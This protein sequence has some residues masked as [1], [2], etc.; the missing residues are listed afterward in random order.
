MRKIFFVALLNLF[1]VC[2]YASMPQVVAHRGYH[3]A[4]G[5]AENSIRALVKADSIGAEF[6]EFDVWISA[7][8]VLFVNHNADI[9]GVV[10]EKS[11]S[12]DISNQK[13]KNGEF[14]PKLET[15]LDSAANLNIGLVLE[16]KP[17][18]DSLRENVAVPLIIE[19][20]RKK[21]LDDRTTYITFSENACRLLVEQ[22]GRP[23]YYLTGSAPEKIA[24]LGVTGPDF[25][26]SHFRKNPDWLPTFKAEGKPVNIWTVDKPEDISFCIENGAD[27]IT[28]NEP[29]LV[30][31]MRAEAPVSANE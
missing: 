30:Q 14:I 15:F 23:V 17:H 22:S 20:V 7:D 24:E 4:E 19:M 13:L 31:K 26:I 16:V 25:H 6:C 9:N 21:G 5:S 29:E 27:F 8:D 1:A 2:L 11:N 10:I 12:R 28:T 3:R 18:A